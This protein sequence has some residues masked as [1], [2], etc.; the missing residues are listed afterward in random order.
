MRL[1]FLLLQIFTARFKV[2]QAPRQAL[3][4]TGNSALD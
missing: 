1:V 4:E 3:I 2:G